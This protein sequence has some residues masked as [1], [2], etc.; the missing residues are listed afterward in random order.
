MKNSILAILTIVLFMV[1]CTDKNTINMKMTNVNG[2]EEKSHVLS[3]GIKVGEVA[4]ISIF[5]RK[6]VN[7]L[8]EL[9]ENFHI[10]IGSEASLISTDIM[11]T[12]AISLELSNNDDYYG[13]LDTLLCIDKSATILD[14]MLIRINTAIEEIADS[15]PKLI[16]ENQK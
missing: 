1:S 11:G 16:N 13:T 2:L 9:D 7:V 3:K 5:N 12:R 10:P 14:S 15:I 6:Y 8:L 4:E